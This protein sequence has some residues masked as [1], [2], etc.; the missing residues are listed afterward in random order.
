MN[1]DVLQW[2]LETWLND[3]RATF[4]TRHPEYTQ[5][6]KDSAERYAAFQVLHMAWSYPGQLAVDVVNVPKY[7]EE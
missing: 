4:N 7:L 1:R 5:L 3:H 6:R 2:D